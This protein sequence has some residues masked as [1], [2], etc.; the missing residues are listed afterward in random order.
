MLNKERYESTSAILF[1][2]E[3]SFSNALDAQHTRVDELTTASIL[4]ESNATLSS[5]NVSTEGIRKNI[6]LSISC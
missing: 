3:L 6:P 4:K 1:Y 5:A 2:V